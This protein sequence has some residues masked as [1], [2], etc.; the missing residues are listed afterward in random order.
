[1]RR[2]GSARNRS[3]HLRTVRGQTPTAALT[4]CGVYPSSTTR[5]TIASRPAGV[6]GAF[7]WTSIR[8]LRG[9]PKLQQLQLP[10]SEPNGQPVETS[11]LEPQRERL[12]VSPTATSSKVLFSIIAHGR[13]WDAQ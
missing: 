9:S 1:M 13:P 6:R 5:R 11:Q 3:T 4:A 8:F 7:L 2:Q 10:R 12:A